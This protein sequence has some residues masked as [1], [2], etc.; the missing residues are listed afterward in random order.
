MKIVCKSWL[1]KLC[2]KVGRKNCVETLS[3]RLGEQLGGT[4]GEK[5]VPCTLFSVQCTVY[6]TVL[7]STVQ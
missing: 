5:S 2:W 7:Y 1:K 6:I 4:L 3:D